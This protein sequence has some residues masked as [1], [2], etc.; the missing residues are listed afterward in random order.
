M[1]RRVGVVSSSRAIGAFA[2]IASQPHTIGNSMT[3]QYR[4]INWG[5]VV[6]P[7]RWF[8]KEQ[9]STN[10]NLEEEL[11]EIFAN[12]P[13]EVDDYIRPD[14]SWFESLEDTWEWIASFFQPVEKQV[15]IL[16]SLRHDGLLGVDFGGWGAT[17][18]FYGFVLR[19]ITLIPA[20]YSHRNALRMNHLGG[21]LGEIT[22]QQNRAKADKSLSSAEKRV[23][24]EGLVRM[25]SSLMKKHGCAQWK[26]FLQMVTAPLTL[27]AFMAIRRLSVYETDLEQS[28]FLWVTD[29]TLPDPTYMLPVICS[30]M[31]VMNFEMNQKMQKGGRSATGMYMR[32]GVRVGCFGFIYFFANQPSSMFAYWIGLSLA[33]LLQPAL[34]RWQP[35]R[36]FFNFPDPP[37]VAKDTI[38]RSEI[39]GPSLIERMFD[40]AEE[41]AK[42]ESAR[43]EALKKLKEKKYQRIDDF[44]VVF[45]DADAAKSAGGKAK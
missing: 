17:F 30:T 28:S 40:S 2:V 27:S 34:L 9:R 38:L 20:L 26:S 25:K 15:E 37:Q 6:N 14:K 29:L 16:R 36:N 44:D 35:F 42:K 31:F 5:K 13:K 39:K 33:G 3:S 21:P 43:E 24:K 11:P 10:P 18:V 1:M 32:W 8:E 4:C 12:Q 41:K 22:Q 23:I 19:A 7:T 45:D